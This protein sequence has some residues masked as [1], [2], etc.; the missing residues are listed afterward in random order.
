MTPALPDIIL[1]QALAMGAP[2]SPEA[3]GDY[4]AGRL[5]LL[6]MLA[7][8]SAQEAELGVAARLWENRTMRALF[9]RVA[10]DQDATLGAALRL[11]ALGEDTDFAW[12]A[13]DAANADLRRLLILLHEAAE[14]GADPALD[15]EILA[16]YQEMASRRRLDLPAGL[17]G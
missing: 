2:Q 13:L 5:G 10:A 1:G 9:A 12:S 3:G 8:L 7:M 16:L 15:R 6:G 4:L 17:A 11:A 14:A